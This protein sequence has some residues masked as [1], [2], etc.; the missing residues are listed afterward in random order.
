M[1]GGFDFFQNRPLL[2][3]QFPTD[4]GDGLV[5]VFLDAHLTEPGGR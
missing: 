3:L 4:G 1:Q 5:R 2:R